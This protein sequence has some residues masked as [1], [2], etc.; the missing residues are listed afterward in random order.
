MDLDLIR[1]AYYSEKVITY[2][3]KKKLLTDDALLKIEI[4]KYYHDLVCSGVKKTDAFELCGEK[5]HK[6]DKTIEGIIYSL[7]KGI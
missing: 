2:L 4:Y 5:F 6:S 7:N 3:N 1:V